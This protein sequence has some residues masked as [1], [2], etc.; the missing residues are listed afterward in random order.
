MNLFYTDHID[1][2]IASFEEEEARHM[3][4]ALRLRAGDLI[5][6]V[7]G[8]G[9]YYKG[10]VVETGKKYCTAKILAEIQ[11]YGKRPYRIHLAIAPT[12][13]SNRIEW[14]LEK[15]TEIGIDKISLLQTRY[16]ERKKVRIDRLQKILRSAMKQSLKAYLPEIVD[17]QPLSLFLKNGVG[18]EEQKFIAYIDPDV[19]TTLKENYI[20]NSDVCLIVG[21]EGGF[22]SEEVELTIQNGF[23]AVSLG[24]S[25]L[26][27]ETAGLVACHSIHLLNS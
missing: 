8:L 26:R 13:N 3:T 23:K 16:S 15:A 10:Q 6:F 12:K 9:G 17:L 19:K 20:P 4:Q 22:T 27:T 24:N 11:E 2:S 14:L 21:P 25:R 5:H 7:D 18:E 1:E